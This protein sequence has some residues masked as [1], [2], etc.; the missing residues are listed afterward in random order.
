MVALNFY[1]PANTN[2][3]DK[4]MEEHGIVRYGVMTDVPG[5]IS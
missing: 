1:L 5:N 2:I 4:L 3:E